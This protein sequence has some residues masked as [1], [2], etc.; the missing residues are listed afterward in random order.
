MI[1]ELKND[2]YRLKID[3]FGAELISASFNNEEYLHQKEEVY[4]NRSSPVLFPI[5][6]K[7]KNNNYKYK[8]KNY[9]LPIHGLARHKEFTFVEKSQNSLVFSLSEDENSLKHYPF[10][11]TL[12]ITYILKED[13]FDIVY[14]VSSKED[15]LFSLGAH[16]A[17]VLKASLDNTYLEFKEKEELDLLCL[18]LENGCINK[19]VKHYLNSKILP[20]KKNIF[21]NDAL[22]FEA[23]KSQE[24]SL[25][26]KE[27]E[28]SVRIVYED[29][30]FIGFWAPINADFVCMEPWCGIADEEDTNYI[31]EEKKG[32]I[33]LKKNETFSRKLAISFT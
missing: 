29:F 8:N 13:S 10:I 3:S 28:K 6:G 15:I 20:L 26:N 4:W 11:F 12:Q 19:R 1:Y 21:K 30:P 18:N 9:S 17:F 5:V 25:K 7:L 2:K 24:V 33:S 22:I 16:P 23:T 32:I 31:F 14:E 27:N